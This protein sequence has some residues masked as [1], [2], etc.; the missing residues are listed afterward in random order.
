VDVA[1]AGHGI[2]GSVLLP[3]GFGPWHLD[4]PAAK[5][6]NANPA[7]AGQILDAAGY[8]LRGGSKVRTNA[9]GK[10]LSFRLIA[11]ESTSV[12]VAAAQIFRDACAAVGI[13]LTLTTLDANSLG[14]TVYN[15]DAP[16]WDIF[17]WGWDS[18]VYDPDYMLG[19][20]LSSQIGG[21]NDVYYADKHYDALYGQQAAA[22]DAATRQAMVHEAQQYYYDAASYIVMWYQSKLQAYRTD[23]WTGWTP[24]TGGIILNFTRDNYLNARPV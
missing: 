7:K 15:A 2:P 23:T 8:K 3:S 18:G 21:N 10:P 17:V 1:L 9:E 14:N 6:L 16:N 19:I 11:I 5:Q 22:I 12:D 4:I 20:P 13:Q 24:L